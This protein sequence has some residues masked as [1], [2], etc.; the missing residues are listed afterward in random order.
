VQIPETKPKSGGNS[1]TETLPRHS[2]H[3]RSSLALAL[4]SLL[5]TKLLRDALCKL[6]VLVFIALPVS[7][8]IL[9]VIFGA[10]LAGVEGW[11]FGD[12]FWCVLQELTATDIAIVHLPTPDSHVGKIAGCF[13]GLFSLAV[14]GLMIALMGGPLLDPIIEAYNLRPTAG[15]SRPLR[16][17]V[18]KLLIFAFILLPILAV[19][20]S[21]IFGGILSI[22]E[23]G[24]GDGW[25]FTTCFY[26]VLAELTGTDMKIVTSPTPTKV[27]G[28]LMA[29][30]VGLWSL[31]IFGGVLGVMGGPLLGPIINA[32]GAEA[33][34]PELEE[35]LT[36]ISIK[37][38]PHSAA[39]PDSMSV[40]SEVAIL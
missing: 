31:A 17:S 4:N 29:C 1:E 22:A 28:K 19:A 15:T 25:D 32:L 23:G 14:L 11:N 35:R 34:A 9:A 40:V 12:C 27:I 18:N 13:V 10:I 2:M 37:G 26:L 3:G 21:A 33:R 20:L 24:A 39:E 6:S 7:A 30:M 5:H 36:Q 38:P 8:V 16:E